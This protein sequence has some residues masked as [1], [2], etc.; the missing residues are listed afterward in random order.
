MVKAMALVYENLYNNI[1]AENAEKHSKLRVITG[2]SSGNFVNR[3]LSDFPNLKIEMYVGMALQGISQRDHDLY[4]KISD[5]GAGEIY[6]VDKLPM[7]HQKIL[8]FYDGQEAQNIGFVGSANFSYSGFMKQREIMA[9][10]AEPLSDLFR[11][12]KKQSGLCLS[13]N[14]QDVPLMNSFKVF[15]RAGTELSDIRDLDES[16]G[17]YEF[18]HISASDPEYK[19]IAHDTRYATF[20]ES[21][22]KYEQQRSMLNG[23]RKDAPSGRALSYRGFLIKTLVNYKHYFKELPTD[24]RDGN[25]QEKI[26]MLTE[27]TSFKKLNKEKNHFYSAA[28]GAYKNYLRDTKN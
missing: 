1:I 6:Y 21:F 15:K 14:L 13:D 10:T 23:V 20:F 8:E 19:E 11:Y 22:K 28:I 17:T 26:E 25:V 4:R 27:F 18:K 7:V 16:D 2:Y 3:V 9:S 5:N 24:L 12:V